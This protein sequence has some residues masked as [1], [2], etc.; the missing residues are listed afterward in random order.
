M[1]SPRSGY[2]PE[3]VFSTKAARVLLIAVV[4][5]GVL[6]FAI[7]TWHSYYVAKVREL[8]TQ[9]TAAADELTLARS[10]HQLCLEAIERISDRER[11][12]FSESMKVTIVIGEDD[13]SDLVMGWD[14][15]LQTTNGTPSAFTSF[16][17]VFKF[18]SSDQQPTVQERHG[19]GELASPRQNPDRSWE[20]IWCDAKPAGRRYDWD[21]TQHRPP[22]GQ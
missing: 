16:T 20:L 13:D 9:L 22:N 18:P 14:D 6:Y 1:S 19:H 3:G 8:R 15:R 4:L 5:S 12:L 2:A 11:P 21:I 10:A 17:A 7:T